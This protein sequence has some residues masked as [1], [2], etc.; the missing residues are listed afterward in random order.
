[1]EQPEGSKSEGNAETNCKSNREV[2]IKV[3]E[4]TKDNEDYNKFK[5][6]AEN[7][8]NMN[9]QGKFDYF[10][11]PDD[12][13]DGKHSETTLPTDGTQNFDNFS[14]HG[15]NL[16]ECD[17]TFAETIQ[18]IYREESLKSCQSNVGQHNSGQPNSGIPCSDQPNT[19][20]LG[21]GQPDKS[22]PDVVQQKNPLPH[23]FPDPNQPESFG[24]GS[25]SYKGLLHPGLPDTGQSMIGHQDTV[26]HSK[27]VLNTNTNQ[28]DASLPDNKLIAV[29]LNNLP[30]T[31]QS[32]ETL[33]DNK[34]IAVKL[35][36]LPST[37]QSDESLPDNKLIAVKLN[38][39]PSTSQPD[40]SLPDNKLIAVKLNS[41]P[42]TSQPDASLPDNNLVAVKLNTQEPIISQT[43]TSHP[44][45]NQTQTSQQTEQSI[46]G[47]QTAIP[48]NISHQTVGKPN[49]VLSSR[50]RA[51]QGQPTQ[52]RSKAGQANT[53][54]S[55]SHQANPD[56]PNTSQSKAGQPNVSEPI[57]GQANTKQLNK[58]ASI[59]RKP[60]R[61]RQRQ[62]LRTSAASARKI[63]RKALGIPM[64]SLQ[65]QKTDESQQKSSQ[66]LKNQSDSNDLQKQKSK[67]GQPYKDLQ[68]L[69]R[70]KTGQPNSGQLLEN[71]PK[72]IQSNVDEPNTKQLV[73][74]LP[75]PS[76]F[77]ADQHKTSK[78][79][80]IELNTELADTSSEIANLPIA[81]L[82]IARK[83]VA[84][85]PKNQR[86]R[87]S[88]FGISRKAAKKIVKKALGWPDNSLQVSKTEVT[89][90]KKTIQLETSLPDTNLPNTRQPIGSLPKL[91]KL[92]II[93]P[94][95]N[96]HNTSL[97]K[98]SQ[99]IAGQR[100]A[101][102][103][104]SWSKKSAPMPRP[105]TISKIDEG[106]T[107]VTQAKGQQTSGQQKK[108]RK[109]K[110]Y[111][112]RSTRTPAR[113]S[114]KKAA[115]LVDSSSHQVQEKKMDV[116]TFGS[117]EG[118]LC[119][120]AS[121]NKPKNGQSKAGKAKGGSLMHSQL[122]AGQ[123]TNHELNN[124]LPSGSEPL[125]NPPTT[126]Q[127]KQRRKR[128][129][130]FKKSRSAPLAST[131]V[132]LTQ[133]K[134]SDRFAPEIH[135]NEK[136]HLE[137]LVNSK[138]VTRSLEKV[139]K[140]KQKDSQTVSQDMWSK[141]F[142]S[143]R[144]KPSRGTRENG[145]NKVLGVRRSKANI[146][147]DKW[148]F[149]P[150]PRKCY[151]TMGTEGGRKCIYC[152]NM[153]ALSY[154]RRHLASHTKASKTLEFDSSLKPETRSKKGLL[155]C[156]SMKSKV[157]KQDS[158]RQAQRHSPKNDITDQ[159]NSPELNKT[160]KH[161]NTGNTDISM[162]QTPKITK[163][164]KKLS[165]SHD[166]TNENV[167]QKDACTDRKNSPKTA[168]TEKGK[169]TVLR[170]QR[171]RNFQVVSKKRAFTPR[172]KKYPDSQPLI[173][174][175][176]C[177]NSYI[178]RY[179]R[180][181]QLLHEK[182]DSAVEY[183]VVG[184]SAL[185]EPEKTNDSD[186]ATTDAAKTMD[187]AVQVGSHGLVNSANEGASLVNPAK[188]LRKGKHRKLRKHLFARRKGRRNPTSKRGLNQLKSAQAEVAFGSCFKEETVQNTFGWLPKIKKDHS[189][190]RKS[191]K[192]GPGAKSKTE[193]NKIVT[194]LKVK[195]VD[196]RKS[197]KENQINDRHRVM[198]QVNDDLE[199]ESEDNRKKETKC[200]PSSATDGYGE[201]FSSIKERPNIDVTLSKALH[202]MQ[203]PANRTPYPFKGRTYEYQSRNCSLRESSESDRAARR[204]KIET[205]NR[206]DGERV[207]HDLR[208]PGTSHCQRKG[209]IESSP[210]MPS[211]ME[212]PSKMSENLKE[213]RSTSNEMPF[214]TLGI[215]ETALPSKPLEI[216]V[217]EKPLTTLPKRKTS[218]SGPT[219]RKCLVPQ[220]S[221]ICSTVSGEAH[222]QPRPRLL[223]NVE[224][225]ESP[226]KQ[227]IK[228]RR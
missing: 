109:R 203:P 165:P 58:P 218:S 57:T 136:D 115:E 51:T 181:H 126:C 155:D 112:G 85:L 142:S 63:V 97:Q 182:Q 177:G 60:K 194:P 131:D 107:N 6:F 9:A 143:R 225:E 48:S 120:A 191:R 73:C 164:G 166:E 31:N 179:F 154:Y 173:Q 157:G 103:T 133:D 219:P 128:R 86:K 95:A 75:K 82:P 117:D 92:N 20:H 71:E 34:L 127:P 61:W 5:T 69:S 220:P 210:N 169:S 161:V 104:T 183:A 8:E 167:G 36:N 189:S 207:P 17:D 2:V 195:L 185:A 187:G 102:P 198:E 209:I 3:V 54:L 81:G 145:K 28:P 121:S 180:K 19:I 22:Q 94:N 106:L 39:L 184:T 88:D 197:V 24:H 68:N 152:G 32:D 89:R 156:Q 77:N 83:P 10:T 25:Q 15:N 188:K 108:R 175:K 37:N 12:D 196:S 52:S 79:D 26:Q 140:E 35:H 134:E 150:R 163:N 148:G 216:N 100:N 72:S 192:L 38:S 208:G 23:C 105:Q 113:K 205:L 186:L 174:C 44:S 16:V 21:V 227:G 172:P 96:Q 201:T 45:Y 62:P 122:N 116:Y 132:P 159:K 70:V 13:G 170:L 224:D 153:Y 204:N 212:F 87:R 65:I 151:E 76:Q 30:N 146:H 99:S 124:D 46:A 160:D 176:L 11:F 171:K 84:N 7:I 223:K 78:Q 111:F 139:P 213:D 41:S 50:S 18:D 190:L 93:L 226:T 129:H 42:S 141:L 55:S 228:R 217:Q 91:S 114:A 162:M 200:L 43:K 64:N 47:Q 53:V 33:P 49:T 59:T 123:S 66:S 74:Q 110:T 29:K 56:Q 4:I 158:E 101:G 40:A 178:K 149:T 1:M 193:M 90:H 130:D 27:P 222:D 206:Q 67:T 144:N 125:I 168:E 202:T 135:K 14:N 215:H 214:L 199:R 137:I 221:P 119:H 147:K 80:S 211:L 118:D 98:E 138:D